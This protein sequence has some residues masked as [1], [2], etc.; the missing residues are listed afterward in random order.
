MELVF[1]AMEKHPEAPGFLL[2]GFPANLTQSKL[3]KEK[4]GSPVKL[5]VLEVPDAVMMSRLVFFRKR[6]D[7]PIYLFYIRL[8]DGEN[9]ND[10]DDTIKKRIKTY[11][12]ETR[13]VIGDNSK[14]V[15]TVSSSRRHKRTC[16]THAWLK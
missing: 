6:L 14:V 4:M 8:K 2:D 12:D 16:K 10:T 11:N 5:I 13:P 15:V 7:K 3:C 1:Q 9:F